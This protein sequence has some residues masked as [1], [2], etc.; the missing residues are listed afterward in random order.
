MNTTIILLK[1]TFLITILFFGVVGF[2][3]CSSTNHKRRRHTKVTKTR[4]SMNIKNTRNY[5]KRPW[6]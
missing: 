4:K 3:S 1:R 5:R 6:Y 2:A